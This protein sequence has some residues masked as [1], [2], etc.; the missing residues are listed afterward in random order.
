MKL[1]QLMLLNKRNTTMNCKIFSSVTKVTK[2]GEFVYEKLTP[3]P[4]F[5]SSKLTIE[6]LE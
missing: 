3:Q 1:G 4:A 6:M 2:K 5:T